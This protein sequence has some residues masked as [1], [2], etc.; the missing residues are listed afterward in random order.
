MTIEVAPDWWKTLFDDVYLLT[1]ARSVCDDQLSAREVD[2]ICDLLPLDRDHLI[3]DLCGGQGRHSLELASRGYTGCTVLDYSQFL[4][5]RGKDIAKERECPVRF[6]QGDARDTGLPDSTFDHILIMGN[7]LGYL[8]EAKDDRKIIREAHRLLKP[9]GILLV[10]VADGGKVKEDISPIA[11]HETDGTVVVCRERVL[12]GNAV[13]A[14]E[15][16][17]CKEKGLL[18]DQAYRIRLFES[19][20]LAGLMEKTG[21]CE[22]EVRKDFSP[23]DRRGDFGFMNRR[24][25]A[26]GVKSTFD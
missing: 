21:F 20:D 12:N 1:D 23:H 16:V 3:L 2:L 18:R 11:W 8:P 5:D 22:I 15:L 17:M 9:G 24:M 4:I 19:A 7:S 10:D 6:L 14:R 26:V 13:K 25:L